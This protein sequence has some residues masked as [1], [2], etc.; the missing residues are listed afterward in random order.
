MI[1]DHLSTSFTSL[2][3]KK[4]SKRRTHEW[5]HVPQEGF[6]EVKLLLK[7]HVPGFHSF[8]VMMFKRLGGKGSVG[9]LM[10]SSAGIPGLL[11][12]IRKLFI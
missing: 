9:E 6:G 7:F 10:N 2:S 11:K 1:T 4:E 3:T 5:G 12:S 8:A